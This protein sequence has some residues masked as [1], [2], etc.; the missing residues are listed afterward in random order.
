MLTGK[1][2]IE[3]EFRDF[4]RALSEIAPLIGSYNWAWVILRHRFRRHGGTGLPW[5]VYGLLRRLFNPAK[6][7]FI[8]RTGDGVLYVG[9]VRDS[10]SVLC[11]INPRCEA[12]MPRIVE[13]H[14]R[15]RVGSY[16]DLGANMGLVAATVAMRLPERT[17]LAFEPIPDTARR[18]AA[19]F[20]LNKLTNVR[21]FQCGVGAACEDVEF[22]F[23]TSDSAAASANVSTYDS[24]VMRVPCVSLDSLLFSKTV[25][26]VA[27]IKLDVEG[28]E[29]QAVRGGHK[30]LLLSQPDVIFEY[31]A[32]IASKLGWVA[33]DVMAELRKVGQYRFK[34]LHWGDLVTE[35]PVS[36]DESVNVVCECEDVV[37]QPQSAAPNEKTTPGNF[38]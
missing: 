11:A 12:T 4:D 23:S 30:L 26:N 36:A 21:L 9:D 19:T 10:Y 24:V 37:R 5:R 3:N 1:P 34:V 2:A 29:L 33:E 27:V 38:P 16:L 14:L 32:E 13:E 35:P 7:Y 20:A 31:H 25:D 17:V 8:G 28:N 18:A 6:P 22:S 15:S